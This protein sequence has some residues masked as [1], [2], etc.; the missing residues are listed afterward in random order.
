MYKKTDITKEE[1]V[2]QASKLSGYAITDISPIMDA[3]FDAIRQDLNDGKSVL[4][5]GFGVFDTPIRK[6]RKVRNPKNGKEMVMK[7]HRVP[8]FK[9]SRGLFEEVAWSDR[10]KDYYFSE[11]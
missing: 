11:V 8:R 9:P 5:S 1:L 2:R 4:V 3:L 7:E 6:G 10:G